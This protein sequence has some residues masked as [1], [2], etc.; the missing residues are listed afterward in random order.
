MRDK[1]KLE[2]EN[3][4]DYLQNYDGETPLVQLSPELTISRATLFET[5]DYAANE[6]AQN[7]NL[8]NLQKAELQN[9]IVSQI[10]KGQL[11]LPEIMP[12]S[13]EKWYKELVRRI[14]TRTIER[15]EVE[16]HSEPKFL[17]KKN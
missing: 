17:A 1:Y 5:L 7:L 8:R 10:K 12:K 13:S 15:L 6:V 14:L 9:L 11:E 2:R 16:A 3:L 4:L